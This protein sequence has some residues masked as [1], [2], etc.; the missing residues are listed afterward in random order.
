MNRC[1]PPSVPLI[2]Y[3]QLHH[4]NRFVKLRKYFITESVVTGG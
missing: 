4:D 3:H 1:F 2:S